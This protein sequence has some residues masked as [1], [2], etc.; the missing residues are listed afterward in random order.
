M[1]AADDDDSDTRIYSYVDF[2]GKHVHVD[3]DVDRVTNMFERRSSPGYLWM[4]A[5][6]DALQS[7][8]FFYNTKMHYYYY[9]ITL[10]A[11]LLLLHN[12][13][14]KLKITTGIFFQLLFYGEH[15]S[16]YY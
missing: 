9:F 12:N 14:K 7:S 8:S 1:L 3:T 10:L 13:E 5:A 6:D 2:M 4:C 15:S 16:N 11:L